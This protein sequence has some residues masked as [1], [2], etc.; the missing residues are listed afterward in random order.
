M[1]YNYE[2]PAPTYE[3]L[4]QQPA[5]RIDYQIIAEA[6]A[7]GQVLGAAEATGGDAGP[8]SGLQ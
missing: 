5:I 1:N 8:P 3:Q 6:A 7:H 4:T 2:V